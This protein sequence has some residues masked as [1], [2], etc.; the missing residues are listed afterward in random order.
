MNFGRSERYRRVDSIVPMINVVFLLMI[1]FLL[2]ASI[3]PPA[4]FEIETPESR[5]ELRAGQDATLYV[6]R[7]GRIVYEGQE[8]EAA[9]A[10]LSQ[11]TSEEALLVRAD[12]LLAGSDAAALLARL[13]SVGVERVRLVVGEAQ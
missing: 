12:R 3:A 2:T 5:A 13:G 10:A 1:F 9:F 7:E 8:G 6:S 4:P 11:R